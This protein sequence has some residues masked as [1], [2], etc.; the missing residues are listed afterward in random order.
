MRAGYLAN[1]E[2]KRGEAL[3][4]TALPDGSKKNMVPC[5]PASAFEA[6]VGFDLELGAGCLQLLGQIRPLGY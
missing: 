3:I 1:S 6:D 4:S 2:I 5:S